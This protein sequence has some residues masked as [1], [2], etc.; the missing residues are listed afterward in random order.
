MLNVKNVKTTFKVAYI[1]RNLENYSS[2]RYCWNFK[3]ILYIDLKAPFD[4]IDS[5][6]KVKTGI[7]NIFFLPKY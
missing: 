2:L 1:F 3:V 4:V 7:R 5:T 6:F